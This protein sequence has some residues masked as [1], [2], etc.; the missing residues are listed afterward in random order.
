MV[1]ESVHSLSKISTQTPETGPCLCTARSPLMP[2]IPRAAVSAGS[3]PTG[4]R[5]VGHQGHPG[6]LGLAEGPGLGQGYKED[7]PV[8]CH[9]KEKGSRWQV[10]LLNL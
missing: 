10:L 3:P 8:T 7:A 6:P 5:E 1:S 4:R 2:A 9:K